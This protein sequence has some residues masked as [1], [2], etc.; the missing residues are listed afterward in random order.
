LRAGFAP[1]VTLVHVPGTLAGGDDVNIATDDA[2]I[3]KVNGRTVVVVAMLQAARGGNAARDAVIVNA[4]T[5][6]VHATG[7]TP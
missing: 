7:I 4:A 3:A 6:A 1:G 5:T 2:G